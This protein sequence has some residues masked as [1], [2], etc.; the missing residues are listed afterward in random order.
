MS[1]PG[2]SS[3]FEF[4]KLLQSMDGLNFMAWHLPY[5]KD[6]PRLKTLA[7]SK[8]SLSLMGY[9]MEEAAMDLIQYQ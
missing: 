6:G 3:L 1:E 7:L 8:K 2:Y 4:G 9:R 5:T